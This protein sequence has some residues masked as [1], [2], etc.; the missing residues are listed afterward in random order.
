MSDTTINQAIG[1]SDADATDLLQKYYTF[2]SSLNPA[3]QAVMKRVVPSVEHAAATIGGGTTVDEL[4]DYLS[5]RTSTSGGSAL[6]V[7]VPSAT[8]VP[9]PTATGV[10]VPATGVPVPSNVATAVPVPGKKHGE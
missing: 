1:L 7:P 8:G 10:P 4:N 3:Q 5:R 6:A 2:S 9:V